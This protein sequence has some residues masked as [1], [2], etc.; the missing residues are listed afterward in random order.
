MAR[1][2]PMSMHLYL[3][4]SSTLELNATIYGLT[5]LQSSFLNENYSREWLNTLSLSAFLS[6]PPKSSLDELPSFDPLP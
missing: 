4:S 1:S 2:K 3:T 5:N 6:E